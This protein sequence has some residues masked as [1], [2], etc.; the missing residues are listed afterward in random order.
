MGLFRRRILSD[1]EILP[2]LPVWVVLS[3]T[4]LDTELHPDDYRHIAYEI[5]RT[6]YSADAG[7]AIYQEDVVPAF[8]GNLLNVA[9]EWS[10]W[11]PDFVRRRVLSK[12]RSRFGLIV[13]QLLLRRPITSEWSR[14]RAAMED[15]GT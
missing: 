4:F 5:L 13:C 14:I 11:S 9:G 15:R 3:D 12:R 8:A 10:G 7:E 1:A 2:C 6:G